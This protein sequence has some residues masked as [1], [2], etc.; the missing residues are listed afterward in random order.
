[1]ALTTASMPAREKDE[2][3]WSF[4]PLFRPALPVVEHETWIRDDLDRFILAKLTEKKILPNVDADRTVLLR[5]AT[6]DLTGLPPTEKELE[7][8]LRD[9]ANDDQ[10]FA[11]VVDRL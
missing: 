7:D 2:A 9:S 1:M 11:K 5:R 4:R 8:F 6:F 3:S 10:A